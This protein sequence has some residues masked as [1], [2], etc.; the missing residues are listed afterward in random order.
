MD[1]LRNL[2][3]LEPHSNG[4]IVRSFTSHAVGPAPVMSDESWKRRVEQVTASR[5]PPS[6][7]WHE[8][9]GPLGHR[10]SSGARRR[11]VERLTPH[12]WDEVVR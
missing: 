3:Y 4:T 12:R 11:A 8:R 6:S 9:E 2:T 10:A 5:L 1:L 7:Q